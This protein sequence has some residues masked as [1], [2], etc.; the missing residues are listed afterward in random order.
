MT[1][2]DY[3]ALNNL[4]QVWRPGKVRAADKAEQLDSAEE[5]GLKKTSHEALEA[6]V[7]RIKL[8][9]RRQHFYGMFIP[10]VLLVVVCS[11]FEP[12][13]SVLF[14]FLLFGPMNEA[15][16]A[17]TSQYW[18]REV[19][20]VIQNTQHT[21]DLGSL[22]QVYRLVSSDEAAS[23][24][25]AIQRLL[26]SH[27]AEEPLNLSPP[28]ERLLYRFLNSGTAGQNPSLVLA[29]LP[30]V[31][32]TQDTT[33][34]PRVRAYK[35][36]WPIGNLGEAVNHCLEVLTAVEENRLLRP[37]QSPVLEPLLRPATNESALGH[38]VLVRVADTPADLSEERQSL[39][40]NVNK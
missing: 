21:S 27:N 36:Q 18:R 15:I 6:S 16:C 28:E 38:E 33:A 2:L 22:L 30:H 26:E 8:W 31:S 17:L 29:I 3:D 11:L 23:I 34:L 5:E 37:S 13:Y 10:M 35:K 25:D 24:R 12:S 9:K 20:A 32:A 4:S 39:N 1:V 7:K 19:P 40:S 14:M